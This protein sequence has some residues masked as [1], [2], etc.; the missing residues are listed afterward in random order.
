MR[1]TLTLDGDV[2]AKL[3][4]EAQ[5]QRRVDCEP[6]FFAFAAVFSAAWRPA[7]LAE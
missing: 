5:T 6:D 3:K 1:T 2:A 7:G 4:T